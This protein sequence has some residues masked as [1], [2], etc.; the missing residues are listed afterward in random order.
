MTYCV[1]CSSTETCNTCLFLLGPRV[2][3]TGWLAYGALGTWW[4]IPAFG[5][6]AAVWSFSNA[7]AH[8]SSPPT[9]PAARMQDGQGPCP[10]LQE[11]V[12][13]AYL[14]GLAGKTGLG[15]SEERRRW[16]ASGTLPL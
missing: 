1:T 3:L 4:A 8:A 16:V 11:I 12:G 7:L 2:G 15:R 6:Y 9:D 13:A 14:V 5:L 10:V